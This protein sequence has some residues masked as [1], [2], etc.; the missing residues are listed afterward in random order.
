M[1]Q[2]RFRTRARD[3]R[4]F[5]DRM[6]PLAKMPDRATGDDL[7]LAANLAVK[8]ADSLDELLK[9]TPPG[10]ICRRIEHDN[11]SYLDYAQ[12]CRHHGQL[13][14]M[15]EALKTNY[16]KME[17]ALKNEVRMKMVTAALTGTA[18]LEPQ[19]DACDRNRYV[20]R[21]LEIADET[22]RRIATES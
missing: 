4:A 16:E 5:A 1:D 17:R 8:A 19:S 18:C 10:C 3:L 6:M 7:Q 2:D 15:R 9:A 20:E 13:Y 21:A 12:S 22:I 11:Y 14:V